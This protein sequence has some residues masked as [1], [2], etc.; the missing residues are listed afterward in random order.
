QSQ[1]LQGGADR[2]ATAGPAEPLAHP[3]DQTAQRPARRRIGAGYRRS[4]GGAL[5][6]TD[7]FAKGGFDLRAKIL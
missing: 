4:G 5:G 3:A 2:L 7:C 1:A 6:G